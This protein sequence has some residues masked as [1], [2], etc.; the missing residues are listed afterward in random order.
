MKKEEKYNWKIR[1][2]LRKHESNIQ[3]F[4]I[5]FLLAVV[6]ESIGAKLV[7]NVF[8]YSQLL[9]WFGLSSVDNQIF[10]CTHPT[11]II[12]VITSLF[13]ALFV[14]IFI[15]KRTK[16]FVSRKIFWITL[17]IIL[18]LSV[19]SHYASLNAIAPITEEVFVSLKWAICF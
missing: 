12:L 18:A 15:S 3:I 19:N 17:L 7:E 1:I 2:W 6:V 5:S 4:I 10:F 13:V 16:G 11:I 8:I 14:D 9:G